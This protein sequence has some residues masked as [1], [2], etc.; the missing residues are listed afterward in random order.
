MRQDDS[1]FAHVSFRRP[2]PDGSEFVV[3]VQPGLVDGR[4]RCVSLIVEPRDSGHITTE[5]L[6]E[7]AIGDLVREAAARQSVASEPDLPAADFAAGGMSPAVLQGV[8]AVYRWAA[9]TGR[10]PL[11]VLFRDYGIQR[12]KASRW[13]KRAR[14]DYPHLFTRP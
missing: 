13:V 10:A 9:E 7:I 1:T 3:W 5:A 4:L 2:A 11:G 8:A 12:G 14:R 6:R